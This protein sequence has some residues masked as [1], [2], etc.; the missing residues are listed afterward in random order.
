MA[1]HTRQH[2]GLDV[3]PVAQITAIFADHDQAVGIGER[4]KAV[5]TLVSSCR[6]PDNPVFCSHDSTYV[7]ASAAR[8]LDIT[9]EDGG[10]HHRRHEI[11]TTKEID[12]G[13]DEQQVCHDR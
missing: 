3:I 11:L 13:S 5:G 4:R 6:D 7:F 8:V 10:H 12:G 1:G 9:V 2:H